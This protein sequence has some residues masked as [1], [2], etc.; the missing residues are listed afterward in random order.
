MAQGLGLERSSKASKSSA[1][2]VE[3]CWENA[4]EV[5]VALQEKAKDAILVLIEKERDGDQINR[6]LLKNVLGIF[7]EVGMGG[8]ETYQNDFE[9]HLLE[10]TA[11]FYKRKAAAWIQVRQPA[12]TEYSRLHENGRSSKHNI[13][14]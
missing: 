10:E 2:F 4:D 9:A 5:Y 7:I 11:V 14:S 6:T 13:D 12:L 1:A 8:M 3:S